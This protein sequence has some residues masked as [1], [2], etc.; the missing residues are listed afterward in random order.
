MSDAAGGGDTFALRLRVWFRTGTFSF[1]EGLPG[2]V[3]SYHVETF[4]PLHANG[5]LIVGLLLFLCSPFAGLVT[6][7]AVSERRW[8]PC[9]L[10][11]IPTSLAL[12]QVPWSDLT[13]SWH[14]LLTTFYVVI[15]CGLGALW[16]ALTVQALR[17]RSHPRLAGAF[18]L[19]LAAMWVHGLTDL[20]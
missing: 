7:S 9:L 15:L 13:L 20:L 6:T 12:R 14:T 10:G 17:T 1:G 11:L 8:A 4:M 18:P 5:L 19:G 2:E 16:I 3:G